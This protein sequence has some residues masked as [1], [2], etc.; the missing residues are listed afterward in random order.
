VGIFEAC[1][2]HEIRLAGRGE[3]NLV[4]S[5]EECVGN[6]EARKL[7]DRAKKDCVCVLQSVG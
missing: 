1:D 7:E 4:P 3:S 5:D 2:T 6:S